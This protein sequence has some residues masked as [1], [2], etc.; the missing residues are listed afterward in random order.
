MKISAIRA[1][2]LGALAMA[3]L[4]V[5]VVGSPAALVAWGHLDAS[6][7]LHPARWLAPDDGSILLTVVTVSGWVAWTVFSVCVVAEAVGVVTSQRYHVKLPGLSA[8]QGIAAGLLVAS[9]TVLSPL[10]RSAVPSVP[11]SDAAPRLPPRSLLL[12][13]RPV[14][15]SMMRASLLSP[16]GLM[17]ICG[18]SLR[19]GTEMAP[20]GDASPLPTP[21]SMLI[22]SSS[23][24]AS[25]FR[26]PQ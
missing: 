14:A 23:V 17:M 19:P 6:T 18:R 10:T 15:R 5:L 4:L 8:V 20:L 25:L 9:L 22:I 13:F 21:M 16:S 2:I 24:S 1:R 7:V 26:E 3:A 11:V 12:R